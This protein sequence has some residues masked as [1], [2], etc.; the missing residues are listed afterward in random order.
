VGAEQQRAV[1]S[2]AVLS[3]SSFPFCPVRRP[4][5]CLCRARLPFVG[6]L[7]AEKSRF[8]KTPLAR[9]THKEM[10]GKQTE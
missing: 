9:A 3:L 1:C 2:R 4:S 5:V 6:G 7:T 10:E 8:G